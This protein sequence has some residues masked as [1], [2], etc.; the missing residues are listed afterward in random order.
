MSFNVI[1][2]HQ[3]F[4]DSTGAVRAGGF[5]TFY[6]NLTTDLASIFSDEALTVA[7]SNPYTLDASG[8]IT[9][10]V[11]Y[12]GLLTLKIQNS[13]LSDTRTD[14]N[15]STLEIFLAPSSDLSDL[16]NAFIAVGN[17]QSGYVVADKA[18][19][20]A[21]TL[22]SADAG[23]K[24]FIT[25]D[26]G[27]D[28]TI[29]FGASAGTYDDDGSAFTG[30]Q[31]TPGDGSSGF[32][33]NYTGDLTAL[34]FGV[35]ASA[36]AAVNG[37][38]L[39]T[40]VNRGSNLGVSVWLPRGYYQSDATLRLYY[41][42]SLN[43]DF[44]SAG[45]GGKMRLYGD[46]EIDNTSLRFLKSDVSNVRGTV[47]DYTGSTGNAI[48]LSKDSSTAS[49]KTGLEKLTVV[50]DTTGYLISSP[51]NP[52]GL[53]NRVSIRVKNNNGLGILWGN[54]WFGSFKDVWIRGET[55]VSGDGTGDELTGSASIGLHINN[56][57][58]GGL[59]EFDSVNVDGFYKNYFVEGSA[60]IA[61]LAFNNCAIQA[62]HNSGF[63]ANV[64]IY[65]LTF[66]QLYLEFNRGVPLRIVT[67]KEIHAL[68]IDGIYDLD[69]NAL[70]ATRSG[71]CVIYL[72]GP[73]TY[74]ITGVACF[75]TYRD[76]LRVGNS[77]VSQ[78]R[79]YIGNAEL[80]TDKASDFPSTS[81][82][83]LTID[84][85]VVGGM[86]T[87]AVI[88]AGGT[89]YT[90]GDIVY[91][92]SDDGTRDAVITID[93]VSAG[94]VTA[95]TLSEGGEGFTSSGTGVATQELEVF[96]VNN[97]KS[98][99]RYPQIKKNIVVESIF[100]IVPSGERVR[101][102]QS[103]DSDIATIHDMGDITASVFLTAGQ[104]HPIVIGANTSGSDKVVN[105]PN[106][107]TLPVDYVRCRI[108]HD[109]ASGA[110]NLVIRTNT[111]ANLVGIIAA[112]QYIDILLD[113]VN[114]RVLGFGVIALTRDAE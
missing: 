10:N 35:S 107:A 42:A 48:E 55:V 99:G 109:G 4:R 7:Q 3:I 16:N 59:Y 88:N 53:L 112:D 52:Q 1:N 32:L 85:T 28:F 104:M 98:G 54:A 51:Y 19:A 103:S 63:S 69:A 23:R 46:G 78:A 80:K 73:I 79:G 30:T 68:K 27:G 84:T 40:V 106:V 111:N 72:D 38:A 66:N 33:R 82:T 49:L 108:I 67:S 101:Y 92:L 26:D 56:T 57:I 89:G 11:K 2:P 29:N 50:G 70:N 95:I 60:F 41:D 97:Q 91:I 12:S 21:L 34:W 74:N 47:I 114:D 81:G 45:Q 36:T 71:G 15:V 37:A 13:D 22:T 43:P 96:L 83:G 17:L 20:V 18:E 76:F 113:K 102:D 94:V 87:A 90:A 105:L 6:N 9:G 110:N 58:E 31:F 75:R 14:D 62:C 24:I 77:N 61:N 93:T 86:V 100:D 44:Q 65:S 5:I 39:Q 25:S 8:R 64:E